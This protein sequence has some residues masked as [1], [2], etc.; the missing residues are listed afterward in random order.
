MRPIIYFQ[1]IP[2]LVL[3]WIVIAVNFYVDLREV[4]TYKRSIVADTPDWANSMKSII[5]MN[6][7][8]KGSISN[9]HNMAQ[10]NFANK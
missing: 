9:A 1:Y 7:V 4:V 10:V 5:P 8:T 2:L 3:F 6:F